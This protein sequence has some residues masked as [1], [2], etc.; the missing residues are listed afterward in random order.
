MQPFVLPKNNLEG[1]MVRAILSKNDAAADI[2]LH[3]LFKSSDDEFCHIYYAH[4]RCG[5][6]AME[7]LSRGGDSLGESVLLEI[8]PT[9]YLV[10]A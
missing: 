4:K 3:V 2:D 7:T 9:Y 10:Y 6:S 5:G 1:S 8:K